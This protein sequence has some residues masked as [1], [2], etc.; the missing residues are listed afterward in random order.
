[1]IGSYPRGFKRG[2]LADLFPRCTRLSNIICFLSSWK[3]ILVV[4]RRSEECLPKR[5]HS[6]CGSGP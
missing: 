5:L 2:T 4:E 6:S 1:M 3:Y